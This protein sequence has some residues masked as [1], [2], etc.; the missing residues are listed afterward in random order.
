[1]GKDTGGKFFAQLKTALVDVIEAGEL[2]DFD[3]AFAGLDPADDRAQQR[4]FA[5]AVPARHAHAHA[6]LE[7]E[8]EAGKEPSLWE[9]VKIKFELTGNLD[10]EKA[11]RAVA[12]SMEKYCSVAETMRRA[13]CNLTWEVVINQK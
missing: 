5:E 2:A 4:G 1:M 9:N 12:L 8:R 6:V 10:K 13:G 11:E 3:G 7:G